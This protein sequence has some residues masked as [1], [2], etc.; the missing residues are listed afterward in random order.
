MNTCPDHVAHPKAIVAIWN[1]ANR[2]KTETLRELAH[3]LLR[4]YPNHRPISPGLPPNTGDFRLVIAIDGLI[5]AIE[6]QGDPHTALQK[7]L[8]ELVEKEKADLIFCATRTKGETVSAVK[9]IAQMG[10]EEVW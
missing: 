8:V 5:V 3:L 10:Y 4:T 2:G 9:H 1:V 6:S 7:R